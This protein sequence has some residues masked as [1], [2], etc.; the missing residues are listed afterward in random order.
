MLGMPSGDHDSQRSGPAR[1]PGPAPGSLPG[2]VPLMAP[3]RAI[4]QAGELRILAPTAILGYGFPEASFEAGLA[5][6]PHVIAVDAGSTD[7][8]PHYLGSG[9][10]FVDRD[11][12]ARD[13]RLILRAAVARRIPVLIG[14]A[15][16]SGAAP[17]LGWTYDIIRSVAAAEGL[18]FRLALISAD[19][20]R[21]RLSA[22]LAAGELVPLGPAP[23]A[24]PEAI[25][26]TTYPVA[27]MGTEPFVA[28]LGAGAEVVLAGRAYDPAVFAAVPIRAGFD[29]GLALHLGKILECAAIAATP[30]SGA[31]C[32]LGT[33]RSDHVEVEPLAP[34]RVCTVTSVA[35]HT[36]YEKSDPYL[37]PGPGGVLDLRSTTFTQVTP[38]AVR[39][40]GTVL[41]RTPY[42]V[43]VEGAAPAG[44]RTIAIAGI[45]DPVLIGQ[46]DAVVAAVRA[47]VAANLGVDSSAY[48]LSVRMY[49][50]NA[51]MGQREP[52]VGPPAH[53]LGLVIE[54]VAPTQ[55]LASQVCGAARSTL[56]HI[57]YPGRISTAG[58]LAFPFSPSDLDMGAVHRFSLHHLL[59]VSDPL[60]LFPIRVEQVGGAS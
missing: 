42:A 58:N 50:K 20:P 11:A 4:P 30:G 22:A 23:A 7:P 45:R 46:I 37:L 33:V 41:R 6:D 9:T 59:P 21:A 51:V 24:T 47:E 39:I 18:R 35:A 43:K 19:V 55:R 12:V 32:M 17:H 49:G 60:E 54:A 36:L 8:G 13:L 16:G 3:A 56:L 40:A 38:R 2:P 34:Q 10:S 52:Y 25:A 27:Q 53:E 15:G 29:A 57:G 1:V 26:A 14:T 31:D 44:Y 5:R 48:T 28:A